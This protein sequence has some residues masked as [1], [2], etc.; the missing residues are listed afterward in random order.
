MFHFEL[1]LVAA[2]P[3]FVIRVLGGIAA[4]EAVA[5]VVAAL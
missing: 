5:V 3:H 1:F 4:V 2:S